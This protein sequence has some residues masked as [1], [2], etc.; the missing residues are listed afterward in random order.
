MT[1]R[2]DMSSYKEWS[3]IPTDL[4][5]YYIV[6]KF[7]HGWLF[8]SQHSD[9]TVFLS[10][11]QLINKGYL[12]EDP[13]SNTRKFSIPQK[14]SNVILVPT[15][16]RD[17]WKGPRLRPVDG[18][19]RKRSNPIE[20]NKKSKHHRRSKSSDIIDKEVVNTQQEVSTSYPYTINI[21]LYRHIE[22]PDINKS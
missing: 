5:Q 6:R 15:S 12:P 2:S 9:D 11:E 20:I 7:K 3:Q 8:R 1:A 19:W 10:R 18:D 21:N 14:P 4:S 17:F 22:P 16:K 13:P